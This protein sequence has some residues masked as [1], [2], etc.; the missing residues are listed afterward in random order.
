MKFSLQLPPRL[1]QV[2]KHRVSE[3]ILLVTK[4]AFVNVESVRITAS[5]PD[6]ILH[7]SVTVS[8]IAIIYSKVDYLFEKS[9]TEGLKN[10]ILVMII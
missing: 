7:V 4:L 5:T 2:S 6:M 9:E 8:L 3:K 1:L 10:M